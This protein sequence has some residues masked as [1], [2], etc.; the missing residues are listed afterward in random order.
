MGDRHI[1]CKLG[2]S[3]GFS[4]VIL[5]SDSSEAVSCLSNS[6][7]NGSW[8]AF[9]ILERVKMMGE[10]F[11]NYRWSWVPRSANMAAYALTS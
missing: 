4:E 3:L 1:T 2:A 10:A 9:P 7:E 11:Q 5:E 6:P 8:E